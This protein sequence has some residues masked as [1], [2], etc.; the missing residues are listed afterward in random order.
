MFRYSRCK[1]WMVKVSG[2]F[3]YIF[4]S[5]EH[6]VLMVSYC[7]RP[8]SVV[9]RRPSTFLLKHLLLW[10]HSLDFDKTSQEWSLGGPLPKLTSSLEP[11]MV[12]WPNSTGTVL[13]WSPTKIV[14]MVVIGW[15]SRSR[16]Q[17][18]GFQNAIF[19]NL[20]VWNYKA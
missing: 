20:L 17:K 10:N 11:L 4:S 12:I 19:K 5:P 18:I 1:E 13:G 9:R 6:K 3:K 8:L 14:Q 16:G 15:I 2:S 7:D